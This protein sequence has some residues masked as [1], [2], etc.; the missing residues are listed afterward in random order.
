M[1]GSKS[2]I[3]TLMAHAAKLRSALK[4]RGIRL[5]DAEC[6]KIVRAVLGARGPRQK[7]LYLMY[8]FFN[9][10]HDASFAQSGTFDFFVM[11]SSPEEAEKLCKKQL[12]KLHRRPIDKGGLEPGTRIYFEFIVELLSLPKRGVMMNLRTYSGLGPPFLWA[13]LPRTE[14][15][16]RHV[17]L[18]SVLDNEGD[19]LEPAAILPMPG[20]TAADEPKQPGQGS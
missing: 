1:T 11:A 7:K 15:Q 5:D 14:D 12:A 16:D 10:P 19:P 8:C 2:T 3:V 13:L 6:T 18:Y 20:E 9:R 4:R 17:S